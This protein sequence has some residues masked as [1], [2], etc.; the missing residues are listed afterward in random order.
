MELSILEGRI[1]GHAATNKKDEA[2]RLFTDRARY[3]KLAAAMQR[4]F[5]LR[6]ELRIL[7]AEETFVCRCE[8]V[9]LGRMRKHTSWKAA[10][11]HTRC[12]MG[13]CQG[14]ICGA[15][16]QVL[17]GWSIAASRPPVLPA[18]CASLAAFSS[19]AHGGSQ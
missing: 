11:L 7:P 17:F 12:G 8:D 13:A 10:K 6:P 9:A 4:A 15:A 3:R 5:R 14:R 19:Q 2:S 18:R 1:A 16:A